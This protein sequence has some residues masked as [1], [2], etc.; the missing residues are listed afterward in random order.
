MSE[1][2]Y[3]KAREDYTKAR[4]DARKMLKPGFVLILVFM[5]IFW[6]IIIR[7]AIK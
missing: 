5:I 6:A 3:T 4:E 1:D 7:F 2:D